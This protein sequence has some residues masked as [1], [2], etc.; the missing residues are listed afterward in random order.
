MLGESTE[1]RFLDTAGVGN[2]A[3]E[4][5]LEGYAQ[6]PERALMAAILF[7]AVQLLLS[8]KTLRR[9]ADLLAVKEARSWIMSQEHDYVF[10]FESVCEGL[11]IDSG[12][13]RLGIINALGSQTRAFRRRD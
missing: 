2:F 11:G 4:A 8:A 12:Y 13:M 3:Q 6:G 5:V 10:S 1:F 9:S 7:D